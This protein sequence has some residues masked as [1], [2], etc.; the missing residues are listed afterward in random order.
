[1]G[2]ENFLCL[3]VVLWFCSFMATAGFTLT[4]DDLTPALKRMASLG[5]DARPVMLAMGNTFMSITQGNFNSVGASY[6]PR[7]WVP[8][9][10]GSPSSLRKTGLLQRS[11]YLNVTSDS[12]TLTSPTPYAAV[13]Q[14]GSDKPSGRGSGIPARPFYPVV[15]GRLTP[16]A[17]EKVLAAARRALD[18]IIKG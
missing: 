7:P 4:K 13:H 18:R 10:D 6:R 3:S 11:F 12:A 14:F 5:H 16:A 15:D 8:K 2:V 9:K 1:M 17:E